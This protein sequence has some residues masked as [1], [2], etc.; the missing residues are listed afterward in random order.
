MTKNALKRSQFYRVSKKFKRR[1]SCA[2]KSSFRYK[3]ASSSQ[4]KQEFS[5]LKYPL[6]CWPQPAAIL[7]RSYPESNGRRSRVCNGGRVQHNQNRCP[8]WTVMSSWTP[9]F[10]VALGTQDLRQ[11]I[12]WSQHVPNNKNE[13]LCPERLSHFFKEVSWIS[14]WQ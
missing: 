2:W 5:R 6:C 4:E 8:R 13:P 11:V 1:C 10:T 14:D 12:W 9:Q 3:A 7:R